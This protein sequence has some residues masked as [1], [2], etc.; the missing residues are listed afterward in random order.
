ML[1]NDLSG[2]VARVIA[3]LRKQTGTELSEREVLDSPH[4]FIGSVGRLAE[5]FEQLRADLAI[6]SFML[7]QVGELEPVVAKLAG[8]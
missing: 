5:K 6:N 2:E 1:T 4:L 8:T 3:A 7:G